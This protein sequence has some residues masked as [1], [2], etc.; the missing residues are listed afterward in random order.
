MRKDHRRS[1]RNAGRGRLDSSQKTAP[2]RL[3]DTGAVARHV[4]RCSGGLRFVRHATRTARMLSAAA[5]PVDPVT[6]EAL[7]SL[8]F[9]YASGVDR[10]D[11]DLFLG[12][13]HHDATLTV[14]RATGGTE[15]PRPMRGHAEIGRV[16]ERIGIY[17][18]TFH[19]LGQSAYALTA[20][21]A[22]G[23]VT[24]IGH[25]LWHDG[26]ELDHVMYIRYADGYR[27]GDD[28]RWRIA[29]RTVVVDWSE[30]RAVESPGR[31]PR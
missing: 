16:I 14:V 5:D 18:Q 6:V 24:C 31:R 19:F 29:A 27:I 8:S 1:C 25:H 4:D 21:G 2:D 9:R 20:E 22:S 12:S 3:F 11:L 7:R 15:P 13:F 30:T 23:D 10:R 17:R 26:G 28:D